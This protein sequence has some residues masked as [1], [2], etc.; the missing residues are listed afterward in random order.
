MA[1]CVLYKCHERQIV[2]Y[3]KCHVAQNFFYY[4]MYMTRLAV[5]I[6]LSALPVSLPSPL[7][8]AN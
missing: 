6:G 3:I 5:G 7:N 8:P 2:F 4:N 1:N